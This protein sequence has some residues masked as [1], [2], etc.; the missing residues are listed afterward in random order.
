MT[1]PR[2]SA[3]RQDLLREAE[4]HLAQAKAAT[5]R[6]DHAEAALWAGMA[7]DIQNYGD[8]ADTST[9]ELSLFDPD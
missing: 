5:A 8:A 3:T 1:A 7:A 4:H 2:A 6:G 9:D